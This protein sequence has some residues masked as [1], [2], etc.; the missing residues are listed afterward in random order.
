MRSA[1]HTVYAYLDDFAGCA[2]TK[3]QADKAYKTFTGLLQHLG[4][5]LAVEKCQAPVQDITWLGYRVSTTDM[6]ISVPETKLQEL[7]AECTAWLQ[8]HR[9]TRKHLQSLL[10]KI[11]HVAPCV[12]HARKFTTR[13]LAALRDMKTRNW[14]MLTDDCKADI[15][16]FN[17]YAAKANGVTIYADHLDYAEVECDACLTGAGG[18]S[19]THCYSWE[20]TDEHR[21]RYTTIHQLEALNILVALRTLA[22]HLSLQNRGLLIYTDNISSN[23]AITTGRTR[24][25]VLAACAR[26][27]WLE[28]AVRD[29]DI[30]IKHKPGHMIPLADALSRASVQLEKKQF[31]DDEIRARGLVRLPPVL[32]GCS[33]FDNHI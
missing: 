14:T 24:D 29:I 20:F 16:W 12:R 25:P 21:A 17:E 31:A 7:K 10:G 28:G 13:L 26:E 32:H 2:P 15:R 23:F 30:K 22:P 27:I 1:G 11:L 4:L 6:I 33:F 18:N 9:V 19:T 5:Q 3:A 8:R